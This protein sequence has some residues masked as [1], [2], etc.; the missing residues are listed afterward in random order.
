MDCGLCFGV[1]TCYHGQ[2]GLNDERMLGI[3]PEH[4]RFCVVLLLLSQDTAWTVVFPQ[5]N[6]VCVGRKHLDRHIFVHP[7]TVLAS[8]SKY[9]KNVILCQT[10]PKYSKL[11][12]NIPNYAKLFQIIPLVCIVELLFEGL[13]KRKLPEFSCDGVSV[14]FDTALHMAIHP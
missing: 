13:C 3:I 7:G 10:M 14:L 2:N 11:C 12:Q 1:C 4:M 9:F 8:R 6:W 5:Q